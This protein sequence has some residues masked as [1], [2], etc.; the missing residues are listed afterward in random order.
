MGHTY[1]PMKVV[2]AV[3][4]LLEDAGVSPDLDTEGYGTAGTMA[5]AGMLLRGLGVFPA[6]DAADHYRRNDVG[7]W[8]DQDNRTAADTR[9]S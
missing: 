9:H 5:G 2:D 3:K 1:D 6:V 4:Q 7:S 8:E